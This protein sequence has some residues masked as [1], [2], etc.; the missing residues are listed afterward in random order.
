[1]ANRDMERLEEAASPHVLRDYV[2]IADGWRGAMI[3]PDGE[4]SWLCF[5]SWSDPATFAGLLGAGGGYRVA[6]TERHLYGGNYDDGTLIWRQRWVTPSGILEVKDAMAYPAERDRAVILRRLTALKGPQVARAT[7]CLSSDYGRVA[8]AQWRRREDVWL[9]EAGAIR[10]RWH[11]ANGAMPLG[12]DVG[13]TAEVRLEAGRHHDLTLE[14]GLGRLHYAAPDADELWKATE[15]AWAQAVPRCADVEAPKDVRRAFAVLRGLT[16]PDGAS[17]AAVTTSLPERAEAGRNYDYR[18]AWIRDSCYIGHA[19]A[20]VE[21]AERVLDDAV[22]WVTQRLLADGPETKP[23][24]AID[25]SAVPPPSHL[26]LPGY[27]GGSDVVGNKVGSQFQLD[28]FGEALLLFAKAAQSERLDADGW[29]AT[30][31]A[32]SAIE[33]HQGRPESGIW[34][35]E[36][37]RWTHSRLICVAGLRSITQRDAPS[38]WRTNALALA[39]SL[40]RTVDGTSLHSSGRWQRAP[41]DPRVDSSLLLSAIRGALSASD[42]RSVATREAILADLSQDGYLYR[43]AEPTA[44]LGTNEGAF[45]ICNF[46]MVLAKLRSGDLGGA[47]QWFER[48]RASCGSSGLFS[49]EYDVAQHQLRGNVPQAFVHALLIESAAELARA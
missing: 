28:L 37:D 15:A 4:M 40:L 47:G 35:I 16:T 9:A 8:S 3:N 34:E 18:Y 19:G 13:L 46:W 7:L 14:L 20:A 24:Y 30:E 21:G 22:R 31:L 23:A 11:G 42:P 27:P 44:E 1:M 43:Y 36:P 41:G 48:T 45:L 6:P 32:I 29:K 25:G 5:P 26:G 10:A 2:L 33:Q 38:R 17:V 12:E 39:D 49:E